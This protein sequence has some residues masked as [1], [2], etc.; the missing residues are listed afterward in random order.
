MCMTLC[1]IGLLNVFSDNNSLII[2]IVIIIIVVIICCCVIMDI[3]FCYCCM[4]KEWNR[5]EK[6]LYV[7]MHVYMLLIEIAYSKS[8]FCMIWMSCAGMSNCNDSIYYH[9][10]LK[11][12]VNKIHSRILDC[13]KKEKFGS[14]AAKS[15]FWQ[16]SP[17]Y[18]THGAYE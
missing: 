4:S 7:H 11:L 15:V 8:F 18:A 1:F 9:D 3:L 16:I 10:S 6:G 14:F 13:H 5:L 17:I 12:F 2:G